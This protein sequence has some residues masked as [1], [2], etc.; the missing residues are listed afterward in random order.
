MIISAHAMMMI[1][2]PFKPASINCLAL[3]ILFVIA[4]ILLYVLMNEFVSFK[5]FCNDKCLLHGL[6]PCVA[7]IKRSG[8]TRE[9]DGVYPREPFVRTALGVPYNSNGPSTMRI[10]YRARSPAAFPSATY[11]IHSRLVSSHH[12]GEESR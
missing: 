4:F 11:D 8:T 10:L 3:L 2:F 5:L 9:F 12:A 7:V 6:H 1:R